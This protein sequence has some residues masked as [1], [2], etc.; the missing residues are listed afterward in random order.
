MI[1]V[2]VNPF[3][4]DITFTKRCKGCII[5]IEQYFEDI[6]FWGFVEFGDGE[7]YHWHVD[8]DG[9]FDVAIYKNGKYETTVPRKIK[10]EYK[11]CE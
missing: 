6:D 7:I 8:Y 5:T 2:V 11:V 3:T 4:R 1:K 10:L 9:A